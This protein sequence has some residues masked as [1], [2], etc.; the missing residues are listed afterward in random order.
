MMLQLC[1]GVSKFELK[2]AF[3]GL[4][5][6]SLRSRAGL[7][8]CCR[9]HVS[10]FC[11]LENEME[12]KLTLSASHYMLLLY[13]GLDRTLYTTTFRHQ[14]F[15]GQMLVVAEGSVNG[16]DLKALPVRNL[17]RPG[18]EPNP[19]LHYKMSM[20]TTQQNSKYVMELYNSQALKTS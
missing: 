7:R 9:K 2:L 18:T 1:F 17:N 19:V 16:N 3:V 5:F 13:H 12:I 11:V 8:V 15:R 14:L 20:C 10:L 6:L 4:H